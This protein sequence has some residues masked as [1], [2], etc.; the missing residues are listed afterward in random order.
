MIIDRQIRSHLI[1]SLDRLL[2]IR[3]TKPSI[4]E[5]NVRLRQKKK[6]RKEKIKRKSKAA[7]MQHMRS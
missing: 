6:K 1:V 4:D 7:T 2:Q 5:R 3:D